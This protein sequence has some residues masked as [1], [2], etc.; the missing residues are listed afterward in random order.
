MRPLPSRWMWVLLGVIG[1]G[2]LFGSPQPVW[3]GET[4]VIYE[5]QFV[6]P[7][8]ERFEGNIVLINGQVRI[9][10]KAVVHGDVV[11][12]GGLLEVKGRITGN[13]TLVNGRAVLYATAQV[14]GDIVKINGELQRYPGA[15]VEGA[16][17]QG[18]KTAAGWTTSG[19][20]D[21]GDKVLAW[22]ARLVRGVVRTIGWSLLAMAVA[23]LVPG[24]LRR[25]GEAYVLH[26]RPALLLGV[27]VFVLLPIVGI[28]LLIT[29]IGIP[30]AL[31]LFA[32]AGVAWVF[33]LLALGWLLGE[34]TFRALGYTQ[35]HP[36]IV[37]GVGNLYLQALL[38][39]LKIFPTF[40]F[41]VFLALGA[42]AIGVTLYTRFG[43]A[44]PENLD[45]WWNAIR[46]LA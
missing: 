2:A 9:E 31:L 46:E 35:G 34:R 14:Q 11:V 25:T 41:L 32:L 36:V 39:V 10:P 21:T 30:I 45:D 23:L 40:Y 28:L 1:L 33:G 43:T 12:L 16:I 17:H 42:A 15:R 37:A 6:V 29:V 20:E 4:K 13:I 26:L 27:L 24:A 19:E 8:G 3:A 18:V 38:S 22:L 7:A 44:M 5:G